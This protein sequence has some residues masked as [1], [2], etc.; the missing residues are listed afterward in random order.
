MRSPR[1]LRPSM[2]LLMLEPLPTAAMLLQEGDVLAG[3]AAFAPFMP[4][5]ADPGSV[6]FE[7]WELCTPGEPLSVA[8]PDGYP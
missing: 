8:A 7:A 4:A 2:P 1:S 3:E 5:F 6:G